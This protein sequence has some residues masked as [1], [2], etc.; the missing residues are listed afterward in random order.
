ME[1]TYLLFY[2]LTFLT[3]FFMGIYNLIYK[4]HCEKAELELQVKI[5]EFVKKFLYLN[6]VASFG[7]AFVIIT[8]MILK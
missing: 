4:K 5:P 7:A 2:L 8:V 1:I 6:A 3:V